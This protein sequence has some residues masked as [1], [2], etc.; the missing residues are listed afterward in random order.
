MTKVISLIQHPINLVRDGEVVLTI[1]PSGNIARVSVSRKQV[2][3]LLG[4]PRYK[5]VYGPVEGLP[6]P[7]EGVVYAVSRLVLDR[8]PERDDLVG[9]D[10][11]PQ[12]AV[13]NEKGHI[14]G[15]LGWQE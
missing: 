11:S 5:S 13:R 7:E 10:T 15:V 4:F 8:S 14:I 2:G 6:A 12:G 9:P 1:N 3:E